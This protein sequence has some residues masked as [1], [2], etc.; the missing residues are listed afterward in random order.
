MARLEDRGQRGLPPPP[1]PTRRGA[2]PWQLS[3]T[4]RNRD[5]PVPREEQAASKLLEELLA[6]QP[7]E[8]APPEPQ[9]AGQ[10]PARDA[11]GPGI[12]RRRAG[13]LPLLVLLIIAGVIAKIALDARET[14]EWRELIPA[15]FIIFFIAHSWWRARRRRAAQGRQEEEA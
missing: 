13:F 4:A 12:S 5:A 10:A 11:A 7:P 1:A 2:N 3:D 9:P 6:G 8:T 15:L 14:G